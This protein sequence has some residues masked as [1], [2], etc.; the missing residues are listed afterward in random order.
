MIKIYYT[1]AYEA[2]APNLSPLNTSLGGFVSSTLVP[3]GKEGALFPNLDK[4]ES[5]RGSFRCMALAFKN[6]SDKTL[7]NLSIQLLNNE[8]LKGEY[9][10]GVISLGEDLKMEKI[11][12][13][14]ELHLLS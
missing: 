11:S 7:S 3:N 5:E 12:Y 6:E 1:G 2:L 8:I 13:P 10:L 9:Y 14:N 4:K